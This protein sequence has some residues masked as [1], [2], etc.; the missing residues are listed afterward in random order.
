[1]TRGFSHRRLENLLIKEETVSGLLIE[2]QK[3]FSQKTRGLFIKDQKVFSQQTERS[4]Y[5]RPECLLIEYQK[6]FSK[7]ISNRSIGFFQRRPEG[8]LLHTTPEDFL[9][10]DW[11]ISQKRR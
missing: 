1:M 3:A 6:V 7:K 10:K 2:A 5:R 8:L 4:S 11:K 9:I